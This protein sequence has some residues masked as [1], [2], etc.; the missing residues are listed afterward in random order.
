MRG[1]ELSA[2]GEE[3]DQQGSR[4]LRT[5]RINVV[6]KEVGIFIVFNS[7]GGYDPHDMDC[8]RRAARDVFTFDLKT[9]R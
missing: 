9:Q 7:A 6:E 5:C 8:M 3:G 2:L 1:N 4:N